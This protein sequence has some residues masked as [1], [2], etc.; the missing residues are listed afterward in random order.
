MLPNGWS[1]PPE[2]STA[3][4]SK[5]KHDLRGKDINF[6]VQQNYGAILRITNKSVTS[7]VEDEPDKQDI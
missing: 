2:N 6:K 3:N 7:V 5:V 1:P 4:F